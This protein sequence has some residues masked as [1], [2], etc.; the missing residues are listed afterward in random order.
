MIKAKAGPSPDAPDKHLTTNRLCNADASLQ[1][2][3]SALRASYFNLSIAA[4]RKILYFI[5]GPL[6]K[7]VS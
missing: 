4:T 7:R 2:S 5:I 1:K 6:I 3:A